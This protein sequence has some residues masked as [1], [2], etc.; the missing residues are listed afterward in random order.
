MA[1]VA[2]T[3]SEPSGSVDRGPSVNRFA[4]GKPLPAR[5][6]HTWGSH[7]TTAA[8]LT[9]CRIQ[10]TARFLAA[11]PAASCWLVPA[12]LP[13]GRPVGA[14]RK[15]RA[16][17]SPPAPATTEI[18]VRT[19]AARQRHQRRPLPRRAGRSLDPAQAPPSLVPC[20]GS[21]VEADARGELDVSS[22]VAS[23]EAIGGSGPVSRTPAA[24]S[25]LSTSRAE[26]LRAGALL[27]QR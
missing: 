27:R 11:A 13:A 7:D 2:T 10:V 20:G 5:S 21:G 8:R 24:T 3:R 19:A 25:S 22:S 26:G 1:A 17:P 23:V 9:C 12:W 18:E 4:G 14:P 16:S 6:V 15:V